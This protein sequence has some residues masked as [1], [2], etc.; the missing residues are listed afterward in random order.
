MESEN[1]ASG[2]FS[3]KRR[4]KIV[5]AL[6]GIIGCLVTTAKRGLGSDRYLNVAES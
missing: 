2:P 5:N 6:L 3:L 1:G 4:S